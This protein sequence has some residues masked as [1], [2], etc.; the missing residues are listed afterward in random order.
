[1]DAPAC[2]LFSQT[3]L[4]ICCSS[5]IKKCSVSSFSPEKSFPSDKVP[6]STTYAVILRFN[7]RRSCVQVTSRISVSPF[8]F[9]SR[10][11]VSN[12]ICEETAAEKKE[13][14]RIH[15]D[16]RRFAEYQNENLR[17][18]SVTAGNITVSSRKE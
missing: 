10:R 13:K 7:K 17:T 1:M 11:S 2:C 18:G 15:R 3:H 8:A 16:S 9:C 6:F 4:A 14:Q 12:R 5:G